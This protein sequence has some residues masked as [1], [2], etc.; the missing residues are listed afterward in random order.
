MSTN[1]T[2]HQILCNAS[3]YHRMNS[4]LCFSRWMDY[5]I[6]PTLDDETVINAEILWKQLQSE[7]DSKILSTL[8][9]LLS[10]EGASAKTRLL[11]VSD[12]GTNIFIMLEWNLQTNSLNYD[13]CLWDVIGLEFA[14]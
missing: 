10:F 4:H 13:G 5:T 1:A 3:T 11:V 7:F 9:V 6:Q 12:T 8:K 2:N 14:N